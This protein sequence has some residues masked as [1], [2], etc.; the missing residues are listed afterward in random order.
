MRRLSR[1]SL[2]ALLGSGAAG[3]AFGGRADAQAAPPAATALPSFTGPSANPYWNS[4]N[5]FVSYP[6]KL[7]LLRMTD[8]GIQLETPRPYFLTP[9][10]PNAAFYVRYHL[11]LIPN[12][13]DLRT[14]RLS[15]EG[16]VERPLQLGFD[17]LV[18]KYKAVSVAAVN[19]C[20]GNSRSRFQP[21]VPG[22]QWG[23]VVWAMPLDR[24]SLERAPRFRGDQ[25]RDGSAAVPGS[26]PRAGAGGKG[27]DAV[28]KSL[29]L[30]DPALDDA[31][32]AYLMND[33]PLPMLN[34]FPVR[35]VVP[36]KFGV[37]WT[38]H[39]TGSARSRVRTPATGWPARIGFP[40]RRRR[41]PRPP[42]RRAARSRRFPSATCACRCDPSSSCPTAAASCHPGCR[43]AFRASPSVV[44]ARS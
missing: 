30:T 37:Y 12:A 11:D 23:N 34:G 28:M 24:G 27:A 29:D 38:K 15:V 1:R 42:Q 9:F 40:I 10:T 41:I 39:L 18:K 14:W 33:E 2:L 26:R 16:N 22:A 19:Q 17:E 4:I 43:C 6:Q 21:R 25:V 3:L 32:V 44:T 7:P 8:R 5:P 35:L 13:V 31:L 20:S 36:G